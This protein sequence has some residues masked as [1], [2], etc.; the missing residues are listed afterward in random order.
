MKRFTAIA[1]AALMVLTVFASVI[2][3]S[4][5]EVTSYEFMAGI[6]NVSDDNISITSIDSPSVLYYA[7]D[8]EEGNET[9]DVVLMDDLKLD[10]QDII[11]TTTIYTLDNG[12]EEVAYLGNPYAVVDS[13]GDWILSQKLV[14]EDAEDDY[15]LRVGEAISFPEG[16]ELVANEIDVEGG[17]VWLTLLKDGDEMDSSVIDSTKTYVYSEDLN[18]NGDKDN[19][20]LNL[21]VENVFAGMTTNM[22]IINNVDLI[23]NEVKEI[24]NND[25]DEISGYEITLS[26]NTL[27]IKLDTDESETLSKDSIEEIL[28][29]F[30]SIKVNE[31]GTK[32]TVVKT[33]TEP[34]TYE[35]MDG[36]T[37]INVSSPLND[38]MNLSSL[39]SPSILYY[40]FDD[41]DGAETLNIT[42]LSDDLK[43]EKQ[44]IIY[45]TTIYTLDNGDKEVAYLGNPYAVVDS[46]GD[47]ILSQKLVNEKAEDD[48]TLRVGEAIS[49]PEG[50][51]LVAN[52]IDVEGGKVWLTLLKDGDEMDSSVIDSTKT[53]VYSEDLNDNGDKDNEVLN[54]TVENVFAGMTTNMVIINNVDLISN[55][56][57]EIENNDDDEIS[58]YEITLSGT[59]LT[60]KLDT[61]ESETLSKDSTEEILGGFVSIK[62]NEEGTLAAAVRSVTIGGEVDEEV[63][64]EEVVEE[65]VVEEEVVEE[66][67]VEEEVV[68]DEVVVDEVVDE[69]VV[70]DEV[71][72]EVVDEEPP[73]EEPGFEAIFA[74]AGLLAVAFLVRRNK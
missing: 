5:V 49:F 44:D 6:T 72:D 1:L 58:G 22:V 64:D 61:D 62:V 14:D 7:F 67:V 50:W 42:V 59:T 68:V 70:V 55:E 17:K 11:Y 47:W 31:E 24:E 69:E 39:N 2:P 28:G 32:A 48:Y 43:L 57:K 71:A 45:T 19:E 37:N 21:T 8:D 40:A 34:G 16:W 27:T 25:D 41:E 20:V 74:I 66:E 73:E 18:D 51:E 33:I 15:T 36:I 60:I 29:G 35:F 56:V 46:T 9:L 10:K 30:V 63:V 13:T 38:T 3:A 52:E 4:A 26:G 54:L 12:D 53:Y 65:E 23:S